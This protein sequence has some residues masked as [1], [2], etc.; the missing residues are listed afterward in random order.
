MWY[1]E[2]GHEI[3]NDF[4]TKEQGWGSRESATLARVYL[5]IS[6]IPVAAAWDARC[7]EGR[8]QW[9][10]ASRS[11]LAVSAIAAPDDDED[12]AGSES[13]SQK[14]LRCSNFPRS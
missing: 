12:D 14:E 3:T 11:M 8:F 2:E 6:M 13:G 10:A 7:G 5:Q 9:P 1:K 4:S